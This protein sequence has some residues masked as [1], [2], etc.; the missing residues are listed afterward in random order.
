VNQPS[1]GDD[2]VVTIVLD[3]T[4]EV[5]MVDRKAATGLFVVV[6]TVIA[7]V[8]VISQERAL[9]ITHVSIVDVVDGRI[10]QDRTV[11]IRGKKIVS[12]RQNG[13]PGLCE[14][15]AS[16]AVGREPKHLLTRRR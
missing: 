11:T 6:A 7:T 4:I 13:A 5:L 15:V 16:S 9:A 8:S 3:S 14:P 1:H 12:V 2:V 10:L